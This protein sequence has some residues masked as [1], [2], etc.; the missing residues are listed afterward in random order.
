MSTRRTAVPDWLAPALA[1]LGPGPLEEAGLRAHV[2]PLFSRALARSA[3]VTYLANHSLCRP[4]DRTAL[5]LAQGVAEWAD[6][7]NEA[8]GPW[9]AAQLRYGVLLAQ[10]LNAP[11]PQAIVPKAS[12][13]QG[14]RAVDALVTI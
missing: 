3:R 14:L 6:G 12:A 2:W 9:Q 7:L 8:W 13:G 1:A 11:S 5:D 4:P 10:L